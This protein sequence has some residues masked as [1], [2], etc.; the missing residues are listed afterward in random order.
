MAAAKDASMT[1]LNN[2]FAQDDVRRWQVLHHNQSVLGIKVVD[3]WH[4]LRTQ[5]MLLAQGICFIAYSV[6]Q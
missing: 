2:S 4:M 1:Y 5:A 6:L 3:G